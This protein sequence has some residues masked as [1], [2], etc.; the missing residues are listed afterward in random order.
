MFHTVK[1]L[2]RHACVIFGRGGRWWISREFSR[3]MMVNGAIAHFALIFCSV[4]SIDSAG[5]VAEG[6]GVGLVVAAVGG[7]QGVA[8]VVVL[9]AK[10]EV[11]AGVEQLACQGGLAAEAVDGPGAEGALL[12]VE[13]Q[14]MVEGADAV[15]GDGQAGIAGHARLTEEEGFLHL[16]GGAAEQVDTAFADGDEAVAADEAVQ[17]VEH[18]VEGGGVGRGGGPGVDAGRIEGAADGTE[19]VG[20]KE[21]GVGQID[22]GGA[23]RRGEVVG[24]EVEG[25]HGGSEAGVY[26]GRSAASLWGQGTGS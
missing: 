10:T 11:E 9:R 17:A 24:V 3:S 6:V 16:D 1:N 25:G 20:G 19:G 4:P 23:G 8:L 7:R 22:D 15:D 2:R 14:Q 12:G 18:G 21:K 13:A 5:G 26:R